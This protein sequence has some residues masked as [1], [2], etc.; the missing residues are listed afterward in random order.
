MVVHWAPNK[1]LFAGAGAALQDCI[2]GMP[3]LVLLRSCI[4]GQSTV[5]AVSHVAQEMLVVQV[6]VTPTGS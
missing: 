3:M 5:G 1:K 4:A 6:T 2:E